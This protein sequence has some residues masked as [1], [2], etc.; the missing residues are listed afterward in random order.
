MK[1]AALVSRACVFAVLA[2]VFWA[3]FL[4]YSVTGALEFSEIV[5]LVTFASL[6]IFLLNWLEEL[7]K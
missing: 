2:V 1:I 5:T 6:T 3:N 4:G 7:S